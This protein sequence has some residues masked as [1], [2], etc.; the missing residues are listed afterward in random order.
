[1]EI[2]MSSTNH[3][4]IVTRESEAFVPRLAGDQLLKA[5]KRLASGLVRCSSVAMVGRWR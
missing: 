4:Y 1:M 2:N 3:G 5:Q